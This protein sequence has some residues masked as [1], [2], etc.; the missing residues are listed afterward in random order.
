MNLCESPALTNIHAFSTEADIEMFPQPLPDLY[1]DEPVSLLLR[2]KTLG[3]HISLTG[4]YGESAWQQT[5]DLTSAHNHAGIHTAWA[6]EKLALLMEK[7]H[8]ANDE[9]DQHG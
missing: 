4:N 7:E 9:S 6:R 8:E 2:G 5:V 1:L 3:D